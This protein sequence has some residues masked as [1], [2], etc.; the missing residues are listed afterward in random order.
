[1]TTPTHPSTERWDCGRQHFV[2]GDSASYE[3]VWCV[4]LGVFALHGPDLSSK[5]FTESELREEFGDND[6]LVRWLE[7][8]KAHPNVGCVYDMLPSSE[9][10]RQI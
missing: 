7:F 6:V 9:L 5:T 8:A 4:Q 2:K 1:M 10:I 3:L